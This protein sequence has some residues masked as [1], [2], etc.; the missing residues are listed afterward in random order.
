MMACNRENERLTSGAGIPAKSCV[1][2]KSGKVN[3][4]KTCIFNYECGHCFFDQWI[5]EVSE[6]RNQGAEPAHSDI[7]LSRAA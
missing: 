2:L 6:N 4:A 5:E 7:V 1:H 3:I